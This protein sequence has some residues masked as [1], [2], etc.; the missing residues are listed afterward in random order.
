MSWNL[1]SLFLL[2]PDW[3]RKL[4]SLVCP[5]PSS[6]FLSCTGSWWR[7]L[8]SRLCWSQTSWLHLAWPT[9]IYTSWPPKTGSCR[10]E[11]PAGWSPGG[12]SR[13]TRVCAGSGR[14]ALLLKERKRLPSRRL[15]CTLLMMTTHTACS[16]LKRWG[17]LLVKCTL[18]FK[19]MGLVRFF[20]C[21]WKKFLMLIKAEFIWF[22]KYSKTVILWNIVLLI[23]N[24]SV[25]FQFFLFLFEA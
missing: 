18:P 11:I 14:W 21:F 2:S 19:S 25:C 3:C 7:T 1:I 4:S 9:P 6:M 17:V 22:K 12:L 13:G 8:L 5:S 20:L 15:W 23:V 16:F 24:L 10:R